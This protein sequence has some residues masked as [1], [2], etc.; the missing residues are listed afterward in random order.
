MYRDAKVTIS[1][2]MF[3][4]VE[5]IRNIKIPWDIYEIKENDAI[6]TCPIVIQEMTLVS[7]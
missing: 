5:G 7:W 6:L 4:F 3:L 2:S 1:S